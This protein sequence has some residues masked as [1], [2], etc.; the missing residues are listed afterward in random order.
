VQ[1]RAGE[2]AASRESFARAL[3]KNYRRATTLYDLACSSAQA[4]DSEAAMRWLS[5]AEMAGM[6]VYS[7][8]Q[9][10]G[11]LR[12]LRSDDRFRAMMDRLDRR[13]QDRKSKGNKK[14]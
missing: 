13:H 1:L 8:A 5:Q 10:D 7:Y 12:P 4:G 2:A 6:D 14:S 9:N 11:D 3:D